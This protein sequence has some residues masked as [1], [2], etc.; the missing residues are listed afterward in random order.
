MREEKDAI[1]IPQRAMMEVQGKVN[2]YVLTDSNTVELREVVTTQKYGDLGLVDEGLS[3][4]DK[5]VYEGL[6][7]IR[8]GMKVVAELDT[9]K[10]K[11]ANPF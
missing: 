8:S 4:N 5:V 2:V 7:R 10:S 6:Q 3:K 9:F 1:L 11:S